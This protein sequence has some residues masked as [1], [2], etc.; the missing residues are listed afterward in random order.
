MTITAVTWCAKSPRPFSI[1]GVRRSNEV[2][3]FLVREGK[4]KLLSGMIY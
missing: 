3:V 2:D 4:W 1:E